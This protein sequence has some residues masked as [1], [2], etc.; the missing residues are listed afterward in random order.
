MNN[1]IN[2]HLKYY[3]YCCWC[4]NK[5]LMLNSFKSIL[6]NVYNIELKL[7]IKNNCVQK[8]HEKWRLFEQ[9]KV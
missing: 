3:I 5:T 6:S 1:I 9:L 8:F 7:A 4:Q 2:Y